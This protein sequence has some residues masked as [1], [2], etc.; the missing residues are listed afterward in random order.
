MCEPA[1]SI[2]QYKDPNDWKDD[3]SGDNDSRGESAQSIKSSYAGQFKKWLKKFGTF[4]HLSTMGKGHSGA[5]H[6]KDASLFTRQYMEPDHAKF[7]TIWW[8]RNL[9]IDTHSSYMRQM[10]CGK[11]DMPSDGILPVEAAREYADAV[12]IGSVSTL[13]RFLEASMRN[14]DKPMAYAEKFVK[15]ILAKRDRKVQAKFRSIDQNLFKL[16]MDNSWD[17]NVHQT[18]SDEGIL[19]VHQRIPFRKR[20]S[21]VKFPLESLIKVVLGLSRRRDILVPTWADNSK[22]WVPGR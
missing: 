5:I 18:V 16:I 21:V 20:R 3:D 8:Q 19:T 10:I 15:C 12:C 17:Y 22:L 14:T 9:V 4:C 11:H 2:V 6:A 1:H 13:R 7:E